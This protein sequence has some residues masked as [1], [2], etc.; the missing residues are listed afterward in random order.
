V[1]ARRVRI[2]RSSRVDI[3]QK[4]IRPEEPAMFVTEF[5]GTESVQLAASASDVFDLLVDVDRLSEWNAH[6]HH[7]IEP[8]DRPLAP[9]V[10]WVV[11]IRAMG[12]RWPSRAR[13]LTVDPAALSLEH[14][15]CSDDGNPSYALWSWQVMPNAQGSSLTVTWAAYPKSF[16][17]RLLL[18]RVRRPILADEVKASLA[19]LDNYLRESLIRPHSRGGSP[20]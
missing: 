2:S 6:I 11:Q 20:A 18:A 12:T 5:H 19:G 7:V 1:N 17:R 10:E 4:I 15:S 9:G 16:W 13:A 14:R 3:A 8:P